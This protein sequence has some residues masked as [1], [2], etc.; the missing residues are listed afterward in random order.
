MPSRSHN[1]LR[2][3][4]GIEMKKNFAGEENPAMVLQNKDAQARAA[5]GGFLRRILPAIGL[6]LAA[7]LVAEFLLGNMSV[8]HLGLLG[9]LAPLYGGGAVL[10]RESVRRTG[11][12]WPAI[13]LLAL[14]YG[15]IEEAFVT[16]SLFN[17]D[18][19][20]LHLHLL[21][22]A[23]I[24]ALGVGAWYTVFVLTLHTVWS[25]SVPIA[26]IESL[27]PQRADLPWIGGVGLGVSG[28]FCLLACFAL[29]SFSIRS[30]AGRFIAS[31]AQFGCSAVLVLALVALAFSVPPRSAVR[32]RLPVPPPWWL[33]TGCFLAGMA[34]LL[35]PPSLGWWAV[36]AC[37]GLDGAA[38]LSIWSWS[39]STCWTA[40]H[41][42]SLAGGAAMAYGVHAFFQIPSLGNAGTATR[43]GNGA[44]LALAAILI[45]V[46]ANRSGRRPGRAADVR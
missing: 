2:R 35:L 45:G 9:I 16:Q 18:Y 37:A 23:A 29:G 39:R 46:G 42:L 27:V 15:L 31:P 11:R 32:S 5:I 30:D 38:I 22:A 24:P 43:I 12:G 4:W 21:Q 1:H 10:I 44:F 33:G 36:L 19:L 25:I 41:R 13:F 14:A 40:I 26:L 17:P 6:F 20:G 3:S 28:A 34:F 8:A 7:P